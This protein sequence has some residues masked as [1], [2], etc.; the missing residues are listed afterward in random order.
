MTAPHNLV[1]VA[2]S[3]PL[4]RIYSGAS[5]AN[6]PVVTLGGNLALAAFGASIALV[7]DLDGDGLPGLAVGAADAA[8]VELFDG[9]FF[10]SRGLLPTPLRRASGFGSTLANLG[11]LDGDGIT[12]LAVGAPGAQQNRGRILVYS[13]DPA[14]PRI[15][16]IIDPDDATEGSASARHRRMPVDPMTGAAS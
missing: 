12:E 11:D 8:Y 4:V 9:P 16:S 14:G 3:Y 5:V 1:P 6:G 2:L 7:G 15:V 13:V 10:P